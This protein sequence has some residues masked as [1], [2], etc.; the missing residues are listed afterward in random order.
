MGTL[1]QFNDA[2]PIWNMIQVG[3]GCPAEHQI[4]PMGAAGEPIGDIEHHSLRTSATEIRKE[5][6]EMG[7]LAIARTMAHDPNNTRQ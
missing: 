6:G 7:G 2:D 3:S 1:P 4:D 5:D